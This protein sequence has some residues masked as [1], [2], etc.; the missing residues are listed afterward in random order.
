M[1]TNLNL[2]RELPLFDADGNP[3]VVVEVPCGSTVKLKYDATLNLF[4]WSRGLPAGVSFPFDFGF[5]PQTLGDDGDAVDA[6]VLGE[7]GAFPGIVVRSRI[8]GALE[9]TQRRDGIPPKRNDRIIAVPINE[10]RMSHIGT[11]RDLPERVLEEIEA[12]FAASLAVT[13]KEVSF[14]GWASAEQAAV[15]I[16]QAHARYQSALA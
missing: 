6:V 5:L 9:V 11:I 8:I 2:L 13:E 16:K 15:L 1:L 4:E 10:H 3:R 12:F 7:A 14:D